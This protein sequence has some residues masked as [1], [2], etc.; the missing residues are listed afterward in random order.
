MKKY[1]RWGIKLLSV[2]IVLCLPFTGMAQPG[3]GCDPAVDP[4][5]VPID[6]GL[7]FLIAA[8]V[9]YGIKK[10]RDSRKKKM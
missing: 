8:G 4:A 9:G 3:P 2:T 6:G 10:V 7:S 1:V 5:C